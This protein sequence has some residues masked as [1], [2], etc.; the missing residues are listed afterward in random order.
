MDNAERFKQIFSFENVQEKYE[1]SFFLKSAVGIDGIGKEKFSSLK[2]NEFAIISHKCLD[3][4]FRFSPYLE[5]LVL[6]GRNKL[7][8]VIAV[9][10]LRDQMVLS[11]LK[12]FLHC[13]ESFKECVHDKLPN[14]L[15]DEVACFVPDEGSNCHFMRTDISGFYDNIEREILMN[16]L[17]KKVK[18]KKALTL[19]FKAI[20]NPIVPRDYQRKLIGN[21]RTPKGVP[22]GLAISNVLSNI[23]LCD[24]DSKVSKLTRKYVRYVDDILIIYDKKKDFH[25]R[26]KI[27]SQLTMLS[28]QLNEAKTSDGPI[29]DSFDFLGYVFGNKVSIRKSSLNKFIQSLASMFANEEQQVQKKLKKF[30]ARTVKYG[31]QEHSIA[32]MTKECYKRIFIEDINEKLTGAICKDEATG[33]LKRY[34]WLFYFARMDDIKILAQIDFMVKNFFRRSALFEHTVPAELKSIVIAHRKIRYALRSKYDNYIHDYSQYSSLAEKLDYIKFRMKLTEPSYS[35]E[36]I[37]ELFDFLVR[38]KLRHLD[39]DVGHMS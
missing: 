33:K 6:K 16:M 32:P 8:R 14:Q 15:I 24:F 30:D 11:L 23:Y 20:S 29:S 25:L 36:R 1:T 12:D 31:G 39:A 37:N 2:E 5:T 3:G 9:P 17:R 19:L 13:E 10:T 4:T 35:E 34:G 21:Y 22:Q 28:L 7:P 38:K 18:C 27:K 26:Q